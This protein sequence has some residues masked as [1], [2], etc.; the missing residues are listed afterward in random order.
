MGQLHRLFAKSGPAHQRELVDSVASLIGTDGLGGLVLRFAASGYG[1]QVESWIR[2][3]PNQRLA[4][5]QL[6]AVVGDDEL[7]RIADNSSIAPRQVAQGLAILVPRAI[8]RLTP[9]GTVPTSATL[10]RSLG[11]LGGLLEAS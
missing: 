6:R 7:V 2:V 1:P 9:E 8:D 5:R 11:H 3:G 4:P 10:R